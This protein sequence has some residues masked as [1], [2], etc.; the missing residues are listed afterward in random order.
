MDLTLRLREATADLHRRIEQ[1]PVA[2]AMIE[3][4]IRREDYVRL[5][6]QL[7]HVHSA[8]ESELTANKALHGVFRPS[9]VRLGAIRGDLSVLGAPLPPSPSA[10]TAALI[11]DVRDLS[12]RAPWALLGCLYVVEGSRMGSMHLVKPLSRALGVTREPGCGLDYHLEGMTGRPLAWMKFKAALLA[13]PLDPLRETQII[14]AA[15][16]TMTGLH[17]IYEAVGRCGGRQSAVHLSGVDEP[18]M[19]VLKGEPV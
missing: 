9:M 14:D 8:L 5:L 12:A 17:E 18:M 4:R 10:E 19:V 16:R 15:V 7:H 11:C 2:Q 3:G 1:L 6:G 13:A